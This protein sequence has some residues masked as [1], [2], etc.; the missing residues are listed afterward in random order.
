MRRTQLDAARTIATAAHEGQTR[1]GKPYISHP[2]AVAFRLED[3]DDQVCGWLH[4]V[5]EDCPFITTA[6][7]LDEG[8]SLENVAT[9]VL[10]THI[11]GESYLDYIKGMMNDARAVRVKLEDL[12]HNL[13]DLPPGTRRDKYL[14]A[15]YIL[16][17][18][19]FP[20]HE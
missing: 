16:K 10:L 19:E 15:E 1:G 7:M 12:A 8:I 13:S 3:P 14:L 4:D 17:H 6:F 9:L 18:V 11:Q 2:A 20:D 5:L